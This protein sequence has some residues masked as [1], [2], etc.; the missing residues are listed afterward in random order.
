MSREDIPES[1]RKFE[2][3]TYRWYS[4]V[5]TKRQAKKEAKESRS[6]GDKARVMPN[7][8]VWDVWYRK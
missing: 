5:G 6:I 8:G 7:G 2:G 4:T 1:Y 3:K